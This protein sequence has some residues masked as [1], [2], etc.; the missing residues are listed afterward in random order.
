MVKGEALWH[1]FI[2]LIRLISQ[3]R[4][5]VIGAGPFR[6]GVGDRGPPTRNPFVGAGAELLQWGQAH[7][8]SCAQLRLYRQPGGLTGYPEVAPSS[9]ASSALGPCVRGHF[10]W[11]S[12]GC[13]AKFL[14]M[15]CLTPLSAHF[16]WQSVRDPRPN[17]LSDTRTGH[18]CPVAAAL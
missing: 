17:A 1:H 15:P 8:D 18:R 14:S 3:A 5:G 16:P 13:F 9:G 11:P 2:A 4:P 12:R 7:R 10:L 6:V